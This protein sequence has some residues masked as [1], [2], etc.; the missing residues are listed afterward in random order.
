MEEAQEMLSKV[1]V[2]FKAAMYRV[3]ECR[4]PDMNIYEKDKEINRMEWEVRRKALEHLVVGS[5]KADVPAVLILTSAVVD[6]ERI[7]DYSKNIYELADIYPE[8]DPIGEDHADFFKQIEA[9]ILGMFD[10]TRDAYKEADAQKAQ[11]AMDTHWQI[12]ERCDKMFEHLALE[13][14]LSVKRAV[15]YT[16]LARYLKRVSSHLKNIA[17][18]VVNPFPRMG[19]R[20]LD[21]G[22]NLDV[23]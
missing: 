5:T 4:D 21:E 17:S 15:I 18:S 19:F 20:A 14:D 8:T 1:E 16:L 12:S 22:E 3:M 6:L 10:L 13:R 2:M 11:T 7:G 9:Q 23:G